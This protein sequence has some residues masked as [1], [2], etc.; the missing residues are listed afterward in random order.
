MGSKTPTTGTPEP[1]DDLVVALPP[2]ILAM[3]AASDASL[4]ATQDAEAAEAEDAAALSAESGEADA[5]DD[6]ASAPELDASDDVVEDASDETVLVAAE[7]ADDGTDAA[8]LGDAD[9][10]E[11]AE[12]AG[13]AGEDAPPA[14]LDA[15][16][17]L[18][19]A[20]V[21]ALPAGAEPSAPAALPAEP[22]E[23]EALLSLPAVLDLTAAGALHAALLNHRGT[24]LALDA[25][26]VK[27]LGG[28]CLQL[29]LSADRTWAADGVPIRL[30]GASEAFDRDLGF[31]GLS[32]DDL[33]QRTAA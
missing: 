10:S 9:P 15:Q 3:M 7:D 12:L 25:G 20:S 22:A 21:G 23:N 26:E 31:M 2:E 4:T 13:V 16:M 5:A 29:L 28:Q 17:A 19:L 1:Q 8:D 18:L 14:D 24:P 27:R 6:L 11:P 30:Q 33:F 32:R